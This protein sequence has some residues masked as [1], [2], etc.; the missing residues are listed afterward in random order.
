MKKFFVAA[1]LVLFCSLAFAQVEPMASSK[2]GGENE[3]SGSK[4]YWKGFK[5]PYTLAINGGVLLPISKSDSKIDLSAGLLVDIE[6][7][8]DETFWGFFLEFEQRKIADC[9]TSIFGG[10]AVLRIP[11]NFGLFAICPKADFGAKFSFGKLRDIQIFGDLG[12]ATTF[13]FGIPCFRPGFELGCR[14]TIDFTHYEGFSSNFN[15]GHGD[16]Y[17]KLILAFEF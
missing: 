9:S 8:P 16:F 2:E 14:G 3:S 6:I 10:G 17:A 7:F 5:G 4:V 13:D 1:A 11:L 12:I 15:L